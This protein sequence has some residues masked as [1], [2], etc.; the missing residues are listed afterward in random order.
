MRILSRQY[1]LLILLFFLLPA[2]AGATDIAREIRAG[3]ESA[4][5]ES[6]G[7]LELGLAAFYFDI[8]ILGL[9]E[10]PDGF[11]IQVALNG[12]YEWNGLFVEAMTESERGLILGYNLGG[13]ERWQMD[14]VLSN[15]HDEISED[16]DDSLEGLR[17]R[18][19]DFMAGVRSTHYFGKSIAQFE[20]LT[21]V[22]D[23]HNGTIF[24]ASVGRYWQR[25]N[26]N[27]H[28]ILQ[29]KRRS[30][31]VVDY[32]L[33]IRE[34]EASDRFPYYKAGGGN[35]FGFEL[36]LTY[37]LSEKWVLRS[38]GQYYHISGEL[39]DSPLATGDDGLMWLT[40]VARVFQ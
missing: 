6:G 19:F 26:W 28:S 5:L 1:G 9:N 8:P 3:S 40:S 7:F 37:P 16:V 33:G 2:P 35:E 14:L 17:D 34:D 4:D 36:G 22:S 39:S 27:F 32:Y 31:K 11:G 15:Q 12:F 38:T 30:E 21:D 20:F 24:T 18:E 23:V 10:E 13:S 25:R 29:V